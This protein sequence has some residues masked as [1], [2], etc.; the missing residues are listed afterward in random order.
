MLNTKIDRVSI[1]ITV[2]PARNS[3]DDFNPELMRETIHL[4][5][6][7]QH[8]I[9]TSCGPYH[10]DSFVELSYATWADAEENVVTDNLQLLSLAIEIYKNCV[11]RRDR[12]KKYTETLVKTS[13]AEKRKQLQKLIK[14][15]AYFEWNDQ[16]DP[17]MVL[18]A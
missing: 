12:V 14:A 10:A 7:V 1:F 8:N 15:E 18:S 4:L 9:K 11:M 3:R 13:D 17:H 6:R 2:F 16:R 5:G